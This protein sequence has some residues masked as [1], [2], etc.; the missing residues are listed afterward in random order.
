MADYIGSTSQMLTLVHASDAKAFIIGT[1]VGICHTL[2]RENPGKTIVHATRLADCP[3][4]KLTTLEKVLWSLEEMKHEVEI[5]L[6]TAEHARRAIQ[7]M[8]D[9][10]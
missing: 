9:L 1:E 5:R 8:L 6:A 2:Q 10:S 4:M 7:R 3:N